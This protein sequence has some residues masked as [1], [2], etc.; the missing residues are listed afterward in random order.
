MCPAGCAPQPFENRAPAV[1]P[2]GFGH[3]S[4][5]VMPALAFLL[6]AFPIG[7]KIFPFNCFL[8]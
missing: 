2:R 7:L 6:P 3:F 4:R 1:L 5:S 8:I